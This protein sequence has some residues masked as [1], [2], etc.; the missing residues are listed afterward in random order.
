[1]KVA[2]E[3]RIGYGELLG[4]TLCL[5]AAISLPLWVPALLDFLK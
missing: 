3:D 1:M 4:L 5:A 2:N